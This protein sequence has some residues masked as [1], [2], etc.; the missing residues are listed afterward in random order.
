LIYYTTYAAIGF[1]G[2][3]NRRPKYGINIA[4]C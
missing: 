2:K 1:F 4:L 3:R